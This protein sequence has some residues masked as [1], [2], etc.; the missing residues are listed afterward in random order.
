MDG[1]EDDRAA[2][3]TN[4]RASWDGEPTVRRLTFAEINAENVRERVRTVV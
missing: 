2:F 3:A 1:H 4:A